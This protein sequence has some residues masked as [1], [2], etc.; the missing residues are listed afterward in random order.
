MFW[1]Y[2][3]VAIRNALRH[4][5]YSFIN[6]AGLAVALAAAILI[7]LYVQQELSF[8]NWLKDGERLYR[9][10]ITWQLPGQ[11]P[12]NN[13][14]APVPL[15]PALVAE[16][17]GVADQTRILRRGQTVE[18]GHRRF[19]EGIN[20]V[21]RNF[22]TFIRLPLISGDPA[23][24]LQ[25]PDS[26]V[27]SETAVTK[28]FGGGDPIG[29][30][31]V[32]D[33]VARRVTGVMHD[34]PYNTQ[35]AGDVFVPYMPP[36]PSP[37]QSA[38]DWS[39][40]PAWTYVRLAPGTDPSVIH[41]AVPGLFARHLPP[42][43]RQALATVFHSSMGKLVNADAVPLRDVHLT[44]DLRR[45]MK[46]GNS[47]AIVYGFAAIAA[48]ILMIA[49]VNFT[50]LATA[51][52]FL[53]SREVGLRK[54]V[55]ATRRQLVTQFL[56]ESVLM[57]L[58]A[59]GFAL[60]AAEILLPLYGGLLGHAITLDYVE[61]WPFVLGTLLVA[62]ACGALGGLYPALVLSGFR[63]AAALR[64]A[65]ENPSRSGLLRQALVVFQFAVSIGLGIAALVIYVQIDYARHMD[66]GFNRDNMV[67][68]DLRQSQ[69]SAEGRKSLMRALADGP[70][71]AGTALSIT[72][73]ADSDFRELNFA[74]VQ[75]NAQKIA[76]QSMSVSPDFFTLYG[77]KLVAGRQFSEDRG[78]DVN[79]GSGLEDNKNIIVDE[80]A[81]RAFGFT[82]ENAIGKSI[83]LVGSHATIVGVVHN[84]LFQ[85]A[86][87]VTTKA[88]VYYYN[89]NH[90]DWLSVRVKGGH[91][92]EA[93]DFIDHT[94]RR[95]VPTTP[96]SRSFVDEKFNALYAD[97]E[98][99]GALLAAF[100]TIAVLIACLGLFGLAAF[101]VDRRTKEIGIRKVMGA[102]NADIVRLLLWQ[103]SVP[104]LFANI[105]AWPVAW[106]YLDRWLAGFAYRIDLNP[107]YFTVAGV[108]ALIIAWATVIGHALRVARANPIHALRYE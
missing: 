23:T 16:T 72:V 2:L 100:V 33:G 106:Y 60:A 92:P 49:C 84:A 48:L 79:S 59:L 74:H 9:I 43:L 30:T 83:D 63:P 44:A 32:F 76:M 28:Y 64:P 10:E 37:G 98:R 70:A 80:D 14:A 88:T 75:G 66:P 11:E 99:Q 93:V 36:P 61:N 38:R 15:G 24:V 52:A 71:V 6:V 96:I 102:T 42:E 78:T 51:R 97:A 56:V 41:A 73:P 81:A 21:D 47:K 82:P 107:L 67:V 95:F 26:V 35:F 46:P 86:Q 22:F 91:I 105:I 19:L 3:T 58:V 68:V 89:P 40:F 25:Q 20:V 53:R 31:L 65:A 8:D 101:V 87:A 45:G 103:F 69:L 12:V 55:G 57:A 29:K 50:N 104:V 108:V 7:G 39:T 34:L 17:T 4:K 27:L 85:G 54:V 13:G 5:L 18:A 77:I 94:W 1:N 90:T 62:L